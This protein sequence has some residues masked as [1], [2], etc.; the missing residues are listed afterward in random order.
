M[1]LFLQESI[2]DSNKDISIEE[3]YE[4]LIE[5]SMDMQD[6]TES[7]LHADFIIHEQ[8]K[9]LTETEA[10]NKKA[11]FLVNIAKALRE[12]ILKVRDKIVGFFSRISG[13]FD[14]LWSKYQAG[15]AYLSMDTKET[16]KFHKLI[17]TVQLLQSKLFNFDSKTASSSEKTSIAN[18][19]KSGLGEVKD[20]M[21]TTTKPVTD[22]LMKNP[23]RNATIFA[24]GGTLITTA[25]SIKVLLTKQS[26]I[27]SDIEQQIAKHKENVNT[28][29]N[30]ALDPK[31]SGRA[32]K[33][34]AK[35]AN[36][37]NTWV[38]GWENE[39][40]NYKFSSSSFLSLSQL[41]SG[42]T[43]ILTSRSKLDTKLTNS[44]NNVKKIE[45]R[46]LAQDTFK[47]L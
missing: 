25:T 39:L 2:E 26:S 20:I 3:A 23:R 19:I 38:R 41:V 36:S 22:V 11:S 33:I 16:E 27:I 28:A 40:N 47:Y 6:L 44:D 7:L 12:F 29:K 18:I 30:I 31:A 45:D 32:A 34:A 21:K 43:N 15:K 8:C 4:G 10:E 5:A 42:I 1:A 17:N 24:F 37:S 13:I 46:L 14:S 35:T 9:V